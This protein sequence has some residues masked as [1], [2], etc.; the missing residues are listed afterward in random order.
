MGMLRRRSLERDED[1]CSVIVEFVDACAD[2]AGVAV[3]AATCREVVDRLAAGFA[4]R[5]GQLVDQLDGGWQ[6]RRFDAA[7]RRLPRQECAL[8]AAFR[9]LVTAELSDAQRAAIGTALDREL[10]AAGPNVV[11]TLRTQ[12]FDEASRE[13]VPRG[14]AVNG[15]ARPPEGSAGSRAR[16]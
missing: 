2:Q 8:D 12:R 10:D 13:L 1:K 11:E 16:S 7:L 14:P 15:P 5:V 6:R 4:D 3:D 9:A